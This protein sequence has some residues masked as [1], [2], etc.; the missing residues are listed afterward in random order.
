M[1][2]NQ[3]TRAERVRRSLAGEPVDRPAISFWAHHFARENSAEELADETVGQFRRYDWDFIKIQNRAS[4]FSEDWGNSYRRSTERAVQPTLLDWPVR[5]VADLRS[6]RPLDPM[7]GVLGEQIEALKTI[8]EGV[9]P[10]VPV[11]STL[12]AP[13]MVLSYLVGESAQRMLEYM[14]GYPGE[15]RAALDMISKTY[16]DYAQACLENGADGIF[17]AI[18]AAS[19]EQMTREEYDTFGL[20]Y[21]RPVLEAAGRGWFNMLHMCGPHL[22]F[23]VVDELPAPLVNWA[24]EPGNP[25]MAEGRD[26]TNRAVI[27]GVSTKPRIREMQPE[28]VAAEVR[29]TLDETGGVRTMIGPG[30]SISPDTPEDNLFAAR[31]A[32]EKWRKG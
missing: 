10:D 1:A 14:R 32:V 11:I 28:E 31:E 20:P 9:G 18:K 17:F 27:G 15:T 2:D 16:Q 19:T 29:A 4:S 23:D 7:S 24:V 25:S 5:S 26:R 6:L 22:Y 30:C 13:A 21:D 8:R 12:F 3:I